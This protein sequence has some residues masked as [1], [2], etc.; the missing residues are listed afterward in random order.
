MKSKVEPNRP[1]PRAPKQGASKGMPKPDSEKEVSGQQRPSSEHGAQNRDDIESGES[2]TACGLS[3]GWLKT[4][5]IGTWF[6]NWSEHIEEFVGPIV[7]GLVVAIVLFIADHIV[8]E[9]DVVGEGGRG[10]RFVESCIKHID[11]QVLL[12]GIWLLCLCALFTGWPPVKCFRRIAVLPFLRFCHHLVLVG[13]GALLP[14]LVVGADATVN[15]TIQIIGVILLLLVAGVEMQVG[16]IY[17]A[18]D[19]RR[20]EKWLPIW[21]HIVVGLLGMIFVSKLLYQQLL[22]SH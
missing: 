7:S 8:P 12:F 1:R 3:I 13:V 18:M 14:L 21:A 16:I 9:G 20:L 19:S 22:A 10:V 4:N 17:C 11:S 15:S 5:R 6:L 2:T